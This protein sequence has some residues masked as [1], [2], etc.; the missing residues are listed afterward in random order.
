MHVANGTYDLKSI[1]AKRTMVMFAAIPVTT[2]TNAPKDV[3]KL[4]AKKAFLPNEP[5]KQI[6]LPISV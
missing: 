5:I 6:T 1:L 2:V 3:Q 4:L